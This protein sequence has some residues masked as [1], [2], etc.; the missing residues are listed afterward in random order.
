MLKV[1]F[2]TFGCRTNIFDT[3]I[4]MNNL[5]NFQVT[6]NI[7][8][9]NFIVVNSCT[10]TN[11]ADST[12]RTFLNKVK[13]DFPEKKILFTGCGVRTRGETLFKNELFDIGFGLSEKEKIDLFLQ[14]NQKKFIKGNLE[15]L[16]KTIVKKII[17]RSRAFIK[18]Q[19]GCN[20]KCSYCIIPQVR[21]ISR[22]YPQKH[23]LEQIKILANNDFSE[24]ILTGTNIG[25]YQNLTQLL[26]KISKIPGVKRIRLGSIEPSQID[27]EFMEIIN[28][29]W[30]GK[31][32]HIAIQYSENSMLKIMKRRNKVENDI[33]LFQKLAESDFAL[34]TDFIVGH[35]GETDEV[36]QNGFNNLKKYPLTHI[37][38]FRYSK[39][40]ETKS[41]KM[42]QIN[43]NRSN[44]KNRFKLM[45][46]LIE[47]NNSK[48]RDS[49]SK[50]LDVLFETKKN[51]FFEGYDQYFNLIKIN[52][53]NDL[54][55]HWVKLQKYNWR[56]SKSQ[57]K[58]I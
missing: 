55:G 14:E 43:F 49:H 20:F 4:M 40:D 39:K 50:N 48:F 13:R 15:F 21:G 31:Y 51:G 38:L 44:V 24:F 42:K 22:S 11:S 25:S 52:N 47:N 1:Y 6:E 36:F 7:E 37:H 5:N 33:K 32:L 8:D 58:P 17:G 16:D 41:A 10:V 28:E 2:K 57:I 27:L 18:I 46:D 56:N 19:E 45:Q 12:C 9:S 30:F 53:D 29:S 3:Q 35:P 26:K 23:I 54:R 34:G